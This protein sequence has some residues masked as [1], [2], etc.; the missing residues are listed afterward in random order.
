MLTQI[1][2]LGV[3]S[4]FVVIFAIKNVGY[5]MEASRCA[6]LSKE[7]RSCDRGLTESDVSDDEGDLG[8]EEGVPLPACRP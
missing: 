7:G 4:I 1:K 3:A 6:A 8:D 2:L 5:S